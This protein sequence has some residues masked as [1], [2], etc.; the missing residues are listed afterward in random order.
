MSAAGIIKERDKLIAEFT[1]EFYQKYSE[2]GL[3]DNPKLQDKISK[4]LMSFVERLIGFE[5][6]I[7]RM[8]PNAK[9]FTEPMIK[10]RCIKYIG[11]ILTNVRQRIAS[12]S[13]VWNAA[14]VGRVER[15]RAKQEA[16]GW[17]PGPGGTLQKIMG[18]GLQRQPIPWPGAGRNVNEYGIVRSLEELERSG[19]F[20]KN[21]NGDFIYIINYLNEIDE[22]K[23]K[24]I[25]EEKR[26]AVR[27]AAEAYIQQEKAKEASK[28]GG[29]GQ[30]KTRRRKSKKRRTR[31]S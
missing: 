23:L 16:S 8:G 26:A 12:E 5:R 28:G 27:A 29:G 10:S 4:E 7:V 14:E 30:R 1:E 3:L 24:L 2:P 18:G 9:T 25:P 19:R 17:I 20:A 21:I 13:A 15:A 31:R 22:E 11:P 6:Q